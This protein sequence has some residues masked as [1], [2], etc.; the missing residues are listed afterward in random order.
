MNFFLQDIREKTEKYQTESLIQADT[1][2]PTS[3]LNLISS[4]LS[5]TLKS[6]II[7]NLKFKQSKIKYVLRI[8]RLNIELVEKTQGKETTII[9]HYND[10]S[11][12]YNKQKMGPAFHKQFID[13]LQ[14]IMTEIEKDQTSVY[15]ETLSTLPDLSPSLPLEKSHPKRVEAL[16]HTPVAVHTVSPETVKKSAKLRQKYSPSQPIIGSK[17]PNLFLTFLNWLR[18]LF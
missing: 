16:S 4:L 18:Q 13:R 5:D 12:F 9:Y 8:T 1:E 10:Q 17:P 2:S 7:T 14:K 6:I 3:F 11:I 15:E